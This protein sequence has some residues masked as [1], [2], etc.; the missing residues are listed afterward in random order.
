MVEN[1]PLHSPG[2]V[3]LV[4]AT[5]VAALIVLGFCAALDN[6][7]RRL[8]HRDLRW[9][10]ERVTTLQRERRAVLSLADTTPL[11]HPRRPGAGHGRGHRTAPSDTVHR[12]LP[13]GRSVLWNRR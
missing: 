6:H 2:G 4:V 3:G 9:Y 5:I 7:Y 8:R 13:H 1:V 10:A 11:R 12:G